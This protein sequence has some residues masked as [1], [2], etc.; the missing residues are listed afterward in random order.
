VIKMNKVKMSY[1]NGQFESLYIGNEKLNNVQSFTINDD[2][3][4]Q[5]Q[6]TVTFCCNLST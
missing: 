2:V 4:S 6:I 1:L 5:T 3:D